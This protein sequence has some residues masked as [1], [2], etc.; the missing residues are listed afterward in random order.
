MSK[1]GGSDMEAQLPIFYTLML[2]QEQVS[3]KIRKE[4]EEMKEKKSDWY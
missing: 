1:N 4:R 2:Q 3:T